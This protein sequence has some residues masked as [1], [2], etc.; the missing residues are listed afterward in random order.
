MRTFSPSRRGFTLIELLVVIAIIAILIGLLLP[1]VQKVRSAA[2][3]IQC[4]N[5]LK[6]IGVALHAFHD[7]HLQLPPGQ[8][9]R[10]DD[11]YGW[12]T[13]ILPYLEQGN[14]YDSLQSAGVFLDP[15]G[16]RD[17]SELDT[18]NSNVRALVGTVIPTYLCPS[19]RMEKLHRSGAAR[20]NYAGCGGD[21][22]HRNANSNGMLRRI[23]YSTTLEVV[24]STDGTAN[25]FMVGETRGWDPVN[26]RINNNGRWWTIWAGNTRRRNHMDVESNLRFGG[27]R[28]PLNSVA[29][30]GT[31]G[32]CFGSLHTGGANFCM[33]D[34]SVHFVQD[35]I[36]LQ[37]YGN[38]A[39]SDDGN[40]VSLGS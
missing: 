26:G 5:N 27:P 34:G 20:S 18:T 32:F 2:A 6:Q 13:F 37:V 14:I 10:D 7:V 17:S 9:R 19:S 35:T 40:P 30:I 23:R 33:G 3:R 31:R 36:N 21:W 24:G 39:R 8:G 11:G 15:R 29:S 38:L 28:L 12:G 1:A 22:Y 16:D 4:S 25:T